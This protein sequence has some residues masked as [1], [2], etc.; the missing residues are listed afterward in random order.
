[1]R[2]SEDIRNWWPLTFNVCRED[3]KHVVRESIGSGYG[4]TAPARSG[5]ADCAALGHASTAGRADVERSR[6]E[7]SYLGPRD[8]VRKAGSIGFPNFSVE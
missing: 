2:G 4:S 3:A 8:A 5:P 1:M 7:T 6:V